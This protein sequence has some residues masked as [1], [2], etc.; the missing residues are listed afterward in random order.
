MQRYNRTNF[1]SSAFASR[2]IAAMQ[3]AMTD[4]YAHYVENRHGQRWLR[5]NVVSLEGDNGYTFQFLAK[6]GQEV[7]HL[8]LQAL[9]VWSNEAERLFT[10]LVNELY[11]RKE[12]PLVTARRRDAEAERESKRPTVNKWLKNKGLRVMQVLTFGALGV[13][14]GVAIAALCDVARM[15]G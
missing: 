6:N 3:G 14:S 8:I 5:V 15:A 13:T 2:L 11:T 4:G 10:G 7:G 1:T 9:F 12:H